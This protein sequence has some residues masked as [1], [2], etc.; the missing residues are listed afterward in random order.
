M[1]TD[2]PY[3][4][5]SPETGVPVEVQAVQ[6]DGS[7]GPVTRAYA[8]NGQVVFGVEHGYRIRE[9]QWLIVTPPG[10]VT[11]SDSEPRRAWWE[12]REV[13]TEGLRRSERRLVATSEWEEVD[14]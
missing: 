4:R 2:R 8:A 9:G 3:V 12:Y 7:S 14:E 10:E 1:M 5:F 13:I 6:Y 11:V